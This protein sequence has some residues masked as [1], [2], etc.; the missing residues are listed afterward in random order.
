MS[1]IQSSCELVGWRSADI[2]GTAR[3]RTVRSMMY[4]RHASASTHSP[5]QSRVV[6][7]RG[8]AIAG[9]GFMG[10][11]DTSCRY[12]SD[13]TEDPDP[14]VVGAIDAATIVAASTLEGQSVVRRRHSIAAVGMHTAR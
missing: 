7:M 6:A 1:M 8:V 9:V 12:L 3:W 13:T 5:T 10:L 11:R 4:I 14:S 2:A